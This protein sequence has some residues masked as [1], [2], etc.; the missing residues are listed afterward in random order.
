[1]LPKWVRSKGGVCPWLDGFPENCASFNS[2]AHRWHPLCAVYTSLLKGA[3]T[4]TEEATACAGGSGWGAGWAVG[5]T[6]MWLH[7]REPLVGE[8]A[9]YGDW[10]SVRP[11]CD[12]VLSSDV[13]IGEIEEREHGI[14]LYELLQLHMYLTLLQIKRWVK[15][16]DLVHDSVVVGSLWERRGGHHACFGDQNTREGTRGGWLFRWVLKAE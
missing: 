2:S 9:R 1:M 8:T 11:G 16:F 13:A 3:M 7:V 5:G 12:A 15:D 6:Q 4:E 14:N 10:I